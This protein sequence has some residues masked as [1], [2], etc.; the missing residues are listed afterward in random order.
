MQLCAIFRHEEVAALLHAVLRWVKV[1]QQGPLIQNS[2]SSTYNDEEVGRELPAGS[3]HS[4]RE[5][6]NRLRAE[7][8]DVDDDNDPAPENIPDQYSTNS[9]PWQIKPVSLSFF[10][11]LGNFSWTIGVGCSFP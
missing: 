9:S 11:A 8:F 3:I 7:G 1:V 5:D 2:A 6:I 10:G 4:T